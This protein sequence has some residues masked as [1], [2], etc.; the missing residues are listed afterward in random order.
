MQI[1]LTL[2]EKGSMYARTAVR[3]M[4]PAFQVSAVDTTAAGDTYT[5]YFLSGI[6]RGLS[7]GGAM[8]LA[9]CASGIA[10]THPGAVASIP[11]LQTVLEAMIP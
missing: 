2:G 8:A 11:Q 1:V 7:V 4:Q 6:L 10:V 5:G 3:Q 9:S